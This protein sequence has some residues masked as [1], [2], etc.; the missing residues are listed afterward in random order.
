MIAMSDVILSMMI[1]L[2]GSI[3]GHDGNL[4]WFRTDEAFETVMLSLLRGVDAILLGRVCLPTPRGLL[5]ICRH[6]L[7][8]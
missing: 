1:S 7:I 8:S 4:D 6:T 3:S 5:A 2:D